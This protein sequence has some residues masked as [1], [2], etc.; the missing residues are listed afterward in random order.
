MLLGA[1]THCAQTCRADP[2][3]PHRNRVAV[4]RALLSPR[5]AG[6]GSRLRERRP[7][8]F[9]PFPKGNCNLKT[10]RAPPTLPTEARPWNSLRPESRQLARPTPRPE[11]ARAMAP[12]RGSSQPGPPGH[13]PLFFQADSILLPAPTRPR[14]CVFCSWLRLSLCLALETRLVWGSRL[15]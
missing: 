2:V 9:F 7:T 10:P 1:D 8:H 3:W 13:R 12:P 14:C 5:S 11:R 6:Q 4:Q 15:A